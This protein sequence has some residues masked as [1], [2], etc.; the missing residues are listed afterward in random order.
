MK[1]TYCNADGEIIGLLDFEQQPQYSTTKFYTGSFV[2]P[3]L[4]FETDEFYEGA[5]AEE[6]AAALKL[7][8]PAEVPLWGMRTILSNMGKEDDVTNAINVLPDPPKTAALNVWQYG[9]AIERNSNTV[10][11]IQNVLEMTDEEVDAIF[12]QAANV[13]V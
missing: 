2:K 9:T 6:I 13:E 7:T 10:L 1:Y 3:K 4:N 5:T 8:V 11:F 12:I